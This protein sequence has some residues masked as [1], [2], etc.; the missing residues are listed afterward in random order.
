MKI[1][2]FESRRIATR[3]AE[4][5]ALVGGEGLPLLHLHGY[6]E[7]HAMW[8]AVAARLRN[9]FALVMADLWVW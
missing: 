3:D 2:G 9:R 5:L 6:P 8:H 7:S 1:E 4:I